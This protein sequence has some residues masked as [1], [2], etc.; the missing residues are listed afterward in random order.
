[1]SFFLMIW[2]FIKT[3]LGL[4]HVRPHALT[5]E[6]K[7]SNVMPESSS[8]GREG[9]ESDTAND[10]TKKDKGKRRVWTL[11]DDDTKRSAFYNGNQVR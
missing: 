8:S 4:G 6:E 10:E 3:I 11:H 1:M 2:T 9:M 7:Q 5:Q